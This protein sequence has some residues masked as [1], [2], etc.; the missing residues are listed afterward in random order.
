VYASGR[1]DAARRKGKKG[2][3]NTEHENE[4]EEE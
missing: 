1:E 4:D 2:E 3:E